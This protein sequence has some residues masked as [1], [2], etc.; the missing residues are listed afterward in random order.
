[1]DPIKDIEIMVENMKNLDGGL[2]SVI[3]KFEDVKSAQ[4]SNLQEVKEEVIPKRL[5]MSAKERALHVCLLALLFNFLIQPVAVLAAAF[6]GMTIAVPGMDMSS[7]F[8]MLGGL[9]GMGGLH[10]L[11]LITAAKNNTQ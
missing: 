1:M 8:A 6:M 3:Q 10:S 11:D 2:Q 5:G 7:V 9:L 4:E